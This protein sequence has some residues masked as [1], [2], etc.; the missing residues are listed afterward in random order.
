MKFFKK[1]LKILFL[2][3]I[4]FIF[5]YPLLFVFLGSIKG[6]DEL[7]NYLGAILSAST[8]PQT[9]TII[10]VYPT[11][12]HYLNVAIDSPAFWVL[13]WNSCKIAIFIL[14]GQLFISVPAAWGFAQCKC[15]KKLFKFYILLMLM[16]FQV[17]MVSEY[18][19]LKSLHLLNTHLG[20]ILPAV[21]STFPIFI[22][23]Q[24]FVNIPSEVIEAAK[25]DGASNFQLFIKIGIPL[26]KYGIFSAFI[27]N[28]I[29]YWNIIEQPII[30][31]KTKALWPLSLYVPEITEQNIGLV[32]TIPIITLI[33]SLL[34]FLLGQEYLQ[35]GISALIK[36]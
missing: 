22:L 7:N 17:R 36:R 3:V 32:F 30:F 4:F 11:I 14:T 8:N 23:Y 12:R 19:V 9:G 29:E 20:I 16:P 10:P 35:N 26:G 15:N 6:I 18:L 25:I 28:F 13:F 1:P 24:F 33:P 2:I 34:I 31:L 21:F 5:C 27:L